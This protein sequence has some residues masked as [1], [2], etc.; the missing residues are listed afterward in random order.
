MIYVEYKAPDDLA[1]WVACF[2][3]IT[4]SG[5]PGAAFRHRVPPDGCADVIFD[6]GRGTSIDLV[7]PMS[8]A[9]VVEL[10]GLNDLLGVRLK[11]GAVAAFG[12]VR[13]DELLDVAVPISLGITTGQLVE[14]ADFR[15]Q[16]RQVIDAVRA[17]IATLEKPDS[18]VRHALARWARAELPDFPS[19][20]ILT[21]DLGLSERAFE[22]RFVANVG[23]TPVMYRRLARFRTVLQLHAHGIRGWAAIAADTGFSD[24][25]H[26][27]R[28]CRAFTGLTPTEWAATQAARAG[29]LQDGAVTT[30]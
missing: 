10:S 12:G 26:L 18:L 30:V 24:Q 4:G 9:Q 20:S 17:R 5:T 23:L 2:W 21:R 29:F 13:A 22:R 27:V 14:T 28:D 1:L 6:L 11:P 15:A 7:G 19:I 16:L 8:T 25:A 3:R